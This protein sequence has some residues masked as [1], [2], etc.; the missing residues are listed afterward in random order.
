MGQPILMVKGEEN[1]TLYGM[2]EAAKYKAMG[3]QFEDENLPEAT[4]DDLTQVKGVSNG[5]AAKMADLR[6]YTFRALANAKIE[7]LT[8]IGGIG[9]TKAEAIM[10]AAQEHLDGVHV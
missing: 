4:A 7:L 10:V 1:I 8:G 9:P 5:Y 3:W 2:A 6:I